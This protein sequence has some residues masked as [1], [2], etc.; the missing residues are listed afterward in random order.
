[1]RHFIFSLFIICTFIIP[2]HAHRIISLAPSLTE[3]MYYIGAEDLLIANTRFC[4][5]PDAAR[6]LPKVGG[7]LDVSIE[8]ILLLKPDYVLM[9]YSGNTKDTAETLEKL[10]IQVIAFEQKEVADILSNISQLGQLLGKDTTRQK[11][12]L[13][14][15]MKKIKNYKK[16]PSAL[17]ILSINPLFGVSTNSFLGDALQTAGWDNALKVSTPYPQLSYENLARINPEVILLMDAL[18]HQEKSLQKI[19]TQMKI[20]P[21]IF[22]I[23]TDTLS[24]PGP[25]LY[26]AILELNR[27]IPKVK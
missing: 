11:K 4:D 2:S 12:D 17:I 24:R 14:K 16:N 5:Y 23:D 18:Q 7:M 3:M 10:G 19:C 9:S 22:T 20:Q 21:R 26:D 25:R 15:K 6:K 8:K 27:L 1:V 13:Q